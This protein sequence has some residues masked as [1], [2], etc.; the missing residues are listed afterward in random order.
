MKKYMHFII[1]GFGLI[2]HLISIP[3]LDLDPLFID[4]VQFNDEAE[5]LKNGLGWINTEGSGVTTATYPSQ[6]IFILICKYLFGS[7]D[8]LA[9][10]I[11]QH[12]FVLITALL[13]YYIG[14]HLT[15][16][17]S[18]ALLSE[19]IVILFPHM[20]YYANILISHV[21]GMMLSVLCL[22]LL[23]RNP[24]KTISYLGIGALWA[25]ATMARFTY[26]LFVPLYV[27]I[28]ILM[29]LKNKEKRRIG[30]LV[31]PVLFAAGFIIVMIP[32][33]VHMKQNDAGSY[34]FSGPWRMCYAFNRAP[35]ERATVSMEFENELK[36]R[37]FSLEEIDRIYREKVFQNIKEHP[38]W[39]I[40][41]G[42]TN[43]SFL[44]INVST[45]EQP[46]MAIYAGIYYS[47]LLGFGFIGLLSLR[48]HQMT[49]YLPAFLL[50]LVIFGV[51]VP[52][53]GYLPNAFPFWALFVPI[54]SKGILLSINSA[55]ESRKERINHS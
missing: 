45:E 32:W 53:Y 9:A 22:Y 28:S 14:L 25:I 42:L 4:A 6:V 39:F 48:R 50:F 10:V 13:V 7:N 34:G 36:E 18:I 31:R 17:R 29:Y 21:L 16:S 38:E 12:V 1:L 40:N 15:R 49:L 19:V 44:L 27:V 54:S 24:E 11:L 35:E 20:I 41:N 3:V 47:I 43:L 37:N 5:N 33:L 23:I 2:I 55:I 30:I 51:H 26:Q 46:H 8:I 52:L